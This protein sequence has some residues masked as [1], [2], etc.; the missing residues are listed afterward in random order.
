MTGILGP[1]GKQGGLAGLGR[2]LAP[3]PR[4]LYK[5]APANL[6]RI[7]D[8]LVGK[9]VYF[10]NPLAFNDPF[11]C[12]LVPDMRGEK[13]EEWLRLVDENPE[14]LRKFGLDPL[15]NEEQEKRV[16]ELR[17]PEFR[18]RI[19]AAIRQHYGQNVGVCCLAEEGDNPMMWGYYASNHKG[20]CYKFDLL[21]IRMRILQDSGILDFPSTE[22]LTLPCFPLTLARKVHY[23]D[24]PFLMDPAKFRA[25]KRDDPCYVKSLA[26]RCE[27]EWRA[28]VYSPK[29][30]PQKSRPESRHLLARFF[31]GNWAPLL[32]EGVLG[33]VILG[34]EMNPDFRRKV[35]AMAKQGG[36]EVYQARTENEKYGLKI[37]PYGE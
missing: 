20:V 5:Y 11:D 14:W 8:V 33:G 25:G 2:P 15:S 18:S 31:R 13:P 28:M 22:G 27:R 9:R 1:I 3:P 12:R 29:L 23:S 37:E 30:F 17:A 35:V 19:I 24:T 21:K 34:C 16:G 7:G 4:F 32:D 6:E 36:V 10:S 26:W